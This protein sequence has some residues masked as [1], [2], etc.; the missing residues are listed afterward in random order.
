[1]EINAVRDAHLEHVRRLIL[2]LVALQWVQKRRTRRFH[3]ALTERIF[4]IRYDIWHGD[5][6]TQILLRRRRWQWRWQWRWRSLTFRNLCARNNWPIINLFHPETGV[7]PISDVKPTAGSPLVLASGSL[8]DKSTRHCKYW[9]WLAK[10]GGENRK[11][12][13]ARQKEKTKT[14]D[15]TTRWRQR[16]LH[17]ATDDCSFRWPKQWL[18]FM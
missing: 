8:I 4:R 15:V 7:G 10:F 9:L 5:H 12:E 18:H 11:D 6:A 16:P 13:N 14:T 3:L 1:M 2:A 17:P